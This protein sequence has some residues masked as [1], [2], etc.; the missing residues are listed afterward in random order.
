[1]NNARKTCLLSSLLLL[2]CVVLTSC[3]KDEEPSAPAQDTPPEVGTRAALLKDF[4]SNYLVEDTQENWTGNA[5]NCEKG[6]ISADSREKALQRL[7]YFRRQVGLTKPLK[8]NDELNAKCQAAALVIHAN[9]NQ[10][11][12]THNPTPD[13]KCY[14]EEGKQA[15]AGNLYY[16]SP[17]HTN[18]LPSVVSTFMVDFGNK[19]VGHRA[20]LL[21]PK[22]ESIGIGAT[23]QHAVI[24]WTTRSGFTY[25]AEEP[26]FVSWP[27]AK[28]FVVAKLV[29]SR[30]S[31][32]LLPKVSGDNLSSAKL[33]MQKKGNK[34]QDISFTTTY[35]SHKRLVWI[36]KNVNKPT[37]S[38]EKNDITYTVTVSGVLLNGKQK[39]LTY[40][41]TLVGH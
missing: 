11:G 17:A 6:D 18:F 13:L 4:E 37:S 35:Q 8:L 30:W 23:N 31:F 9:K 14:T 40:D 16:R 26:E 20:W 24:W 1:M 29:Y 7:N 10:K 2:P 25:S 15:A 19:R 41:V 28:G 27:P 36:P 32:H 33:S 12:F 21:D 38:Q 22:L 39:T 5:E 3:K 34:P